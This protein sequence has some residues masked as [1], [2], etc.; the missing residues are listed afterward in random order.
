MI[1]VPTL[2]AGWAKDPR[3]TKAIGD[4][5]LSGCEAL[6]LPIPSA[7]MPHTHN[8]LFNPLHVDSTTARLFAETFNL[9]ARLVR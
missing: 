1:A 8:Y 9:D 7:I 2:Q 4:R 6:L 5:F 3:Q